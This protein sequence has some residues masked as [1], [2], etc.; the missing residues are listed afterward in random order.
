M[1][2]PAVVSSGAVAVFEGGGA[3]SVIESIISKMWEVLS[4][5]APAITDIAVKAVGAFVPILAT[6]S[7]VWLAIN[8]F[9]RFTARAGR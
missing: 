8:L 4:Q 3:T 9:Q 5:W 7:V 2:S 6:M 1:L